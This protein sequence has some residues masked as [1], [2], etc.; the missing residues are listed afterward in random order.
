[1]CEEVSFASGPIGVVVGLLDGMRGLRLCTFSITSLLLCWSSA[2][3]SRPAL[4]GLYRWV[5]SALDLFCDFLRGVRMKVLGLKR[6]GRRV[7][8]PFIDAPFGKSMV[9]VRSVEVSFRMSF[10]DAAGEVRLPTPVW[11]LPSIG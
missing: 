1:M 4:H 11:E 3:G 10:L 7:E 9:A 5:T 6:S 8:L 2:E